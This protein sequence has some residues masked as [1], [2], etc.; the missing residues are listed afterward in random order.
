[1]TSASTPRPTIPP[2]AAPPPAAKMQPRAGLPNWMRQGRGH[3]EPRA[4]NEYYSHLVGQLKIGLPIVALGLVALV[5]AWPYMSTTQTETSKIDKSQTTMVNARYFARDKQDRPFSVTA[6]SA[7]L[8]AGS[9]SLVDLTQPEGEVTQSNGSWLTITSD[10]GRYNQEDG[11]L[12]MLDNVHLLRDD[13]FEFVT[14]EAEIDTKTG[15]AWGHRKITGQGQSSEIRADGFIASDRGKTIS[16]T[17]SST[18]KIAPAGVTPPA[19]PIAT[20]PITG[21]Q[22]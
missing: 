20:P 1:M 17:H 11:R 10:R 4:Y 5:A 16:F 18:A 13:G 22:K 19:S 2:A 14:D 7:A 8:V 21:P 15:N 6:K 3:D 12:V 9:T